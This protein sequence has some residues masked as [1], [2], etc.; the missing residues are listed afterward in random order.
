LLAD[1]CCTILA[2]RRE[3]VLVSGAIAYATGQ[4]TGISNVFSAGLPAGPLWASAV[5]AVAALRPG[6]PIVGYERG[7]DLAAARQAGCQVLGPLRVWARDP[8]P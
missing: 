4:V 8:A 3:G 1:P 5:Q 2:C 6:L 7:A